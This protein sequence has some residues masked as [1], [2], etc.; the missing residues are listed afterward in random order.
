MSSSPRAIPWGPTRFSRSVRTGSSCS[1]TMIFASSRWTVAWKRKPNA[2]SIRSRSCHCLK[3]FPC[4]CPP[5]APP[6]ASPNNLQTIETSPFSNSK[7]I[8]QMGTFLFSGMVLETEAAEIVSLVRL[9]EDRPD[10]VRSLAAGID[11]AVAA[12]VKLERIHR[13]ELFLSL[14]REGAEAKP[15]EVIPDASKLLAVFSKD[16]R[17]IVC[18]GREQEDDVW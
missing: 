4:P 15:F 14:G 11:D 1:G 2:R 6:P 13:L 16:A 12:R 9:G 8:E 18:G 5:A 7:R 3:T 10:D 17:K